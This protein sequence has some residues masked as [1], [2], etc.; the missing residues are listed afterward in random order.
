MATTVYGCRYSSKNENIN[1]CNLMSYDHG[2]TSS[3][4][5][6]DLHGKKNGWSWQ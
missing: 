5:E 6:M 4:T 3:L 1:S 2:L